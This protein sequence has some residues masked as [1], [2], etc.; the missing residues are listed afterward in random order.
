MRLR[1]LFSLVVYVMLFVTHLFFSDIKKIDFFKKMFMFL[2]WQ[3][4]C[5]INL[6]T[7][8]IGN[9]PLLSSVLFTHSESNG[10]KVI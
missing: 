4:Q 8:G 9:I 7:H 3:T 10:S 2:H 1:D 6:T 5:H